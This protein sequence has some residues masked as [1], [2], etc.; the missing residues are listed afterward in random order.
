MRL[1]WK[2]MLSFMAVMTVLVAI[3]AI[4]FI[5]VTKRTMYSRTFNEL[6]EYADSLIQDNEIIINRKTNQIIGF[7]EQAIDSKSRLLSRQNVNF[8]VYDGSG[9]RRY[10][11]SQGFAP[12]IS[13]SDWK[14]LREGKSLKKQVAYPDPVVLQR[15]QHSLEA[16]QLTVLIKPYF[17]HQKLVAVV[18]IGTFV[19]TIKQQYQK[20]FQNL[21][22]AFLFAIIV[23]ILVSYLL[24]RSMTKRI[25]QMELATKSIAKGDYDVHLPSKGSKDELDNLSDNFNM[26]AASLRSSQED[27]R[28]EEERRKQFLA[29]AA[30]E[31]RTPL[32]TINGL[33]EGLI[34]DAIP[35]EERRHSLE[36]MQKDTKRLIRLVNDNLSYEKLRT[37]QIQ[38]NRQ[39]FD[40]GPSLKNVKDQLTPLAKD[41]DDQLSIDVPH[42]LRVFADQDH[43]VQIMFNI[44]QNAIQFTDKGNI[45]IS[46]RR[47]P[48]GAEFKVTD[49][50]IGMTKSQ[51]SKIFERFYK[52]DRSRMSTKYG[53]SGIGMSLVKE[54][55]ELHHGRIDVQSKLHHGS[56]FTVFFPDRGHDHDQ[57]ENSG[58]SSQ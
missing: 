30:H 24:A 39:T 44:I 56:T 10:D 47:L 13:K 32:T 40:A 54:L 34:Y 29:N 31:M 12:G 4:S 50:G 38:M 52:A 23:S 58:G 14:K 33:L 45:K 3:M 17:F 35:Q 9:Q 26:M 6:N 21:L 25:D 5:S 28:R 16:P 57:Q 48:N 51:I 8:A 27:I 2:Q 36:L 19:S 37:N 15:K 1:I 49:T 53:E 11:N 55:V 7:E 20:I 46:G 43:F 42:P 22:L 41:K 18:S